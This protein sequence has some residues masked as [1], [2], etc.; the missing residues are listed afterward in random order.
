MLPSADGELIGSLLL[1][2]YMYRFYFKQQS[3][4]TY[5][6]FTA[7]DLMTT[8]CIFCVLFAKNQLS[9]LYEII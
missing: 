4:V 9:T 1:N 2:S 6:N 5:K 3:T 7:A 8:G